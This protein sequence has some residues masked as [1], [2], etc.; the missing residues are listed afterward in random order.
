MKVALLEPIRRSS[1]DTR[2]MINTALQPS[3]GDDHLQSPETE[4][5]RWYARSLEYH[6][7]SQHITLSRLTQ[8]LIWKFFSIWDCEIKYFQQYDVLYCSVRETN[9]TALSGNISNASS[10]FA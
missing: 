6:T 1:I 5:E 4:A 7:N 8:K 2:L 10:I 3:L 9:A